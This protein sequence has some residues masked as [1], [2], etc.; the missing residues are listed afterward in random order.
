[1]VTVTEQLDPDPL[2]AAFNAP[3]PGRMKL[4]AILLGPLLM[5]LLPGTLFPIF[6]WFFYYSIPFCT[7]SSPPQRSHWR[8]SYLK[9]LPVTFYLLSLLYFFFV[10]STPYNI[11]SCMYVCVH[12]LLLLFKLHAGRDCR[13]HSWSCHLCL[14]QRLTQSG[15]SITIC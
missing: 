4:Y 13:F 7:Q 14:E 12:L 1:M 9:G 6:P 10:T 3:L 2:P 5:F 15:H 8:S 11:I